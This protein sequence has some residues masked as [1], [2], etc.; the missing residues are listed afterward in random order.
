MVTGHFA[1]E[2][3]LLL[4][5]K[6][7]LRAFVPETLVPLDFATVECLFHNIIALWNTWVRISTFY[8][9]PCCI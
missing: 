1:Y 7:T 4:G 6:Y 8:F 2:T 3:F 9:F 5:E